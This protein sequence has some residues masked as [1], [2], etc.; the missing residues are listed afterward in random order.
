MS[1]SRRNRLSEIMSKAWYLFRT[2]GINFSDALKR[3]WAWFRL[4]AKM[5]KEIVEFWFVKSDGTKR[6]A[7]GTLRSDLLPET[8]G[9]SRRNYEHLQTYFDTEKG[10][11]RC[12]KIVNLSI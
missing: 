4:R 12:F 7:F 10:E 3:A 8:K 9:E 6:Q 5:Q 2:Y 1:E 11:F